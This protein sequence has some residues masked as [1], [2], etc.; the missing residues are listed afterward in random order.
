VPHLPALVPTHRLED[1]YDIRTLQALLGHPEVATPMLY[2]PVLNR[3][4]AAVGSPAESH[5]RGAGVM[6]RFDVVRPCYSARS[7]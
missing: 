1:G 7:R 5:A 4:S 2:A 6:V 3:G